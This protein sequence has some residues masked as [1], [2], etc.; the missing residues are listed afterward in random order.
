MAMG[1]AI[2]AITEA[3]APA[4]AVAALARGMELD[5]GN[6]DLY[7]A[8]VQTML[9]FDLPDLAVPAARALVALRPGDAV[10]WAV[11]G[12]DAARHG[13]LARAVTDVVLAA[14]LA[15]DDPFVLRTA[16]YV[17]AWYDTAPDR[18]AVPASIRASLDALRP[19]LADQ[20]AFNEAYGSAR[21]AY[22]ARAAG[23]AAPAGSQPAF[24][25]P[26]P[27][28][29]ALA[30][31][32]QPAL[33]GVPPSPAPLVT[34]NYYAAPY[35][36]GYAAEGS[37]YEYDGPYYPFYAGSYAPWCYG[38]GYA[39][40]ALVAFPQREHRHEHFGHGAGHEGSAAGRGADRWATPAPAASASAAGGTRVLAWGAQTPEPPE[41][42]EALEPPEA[43]RGVASAGIAGAPRGV[44]EGRTLPPM[45]WVTAPAA[46]RAQTVTTYNPGAAW[47]GSTW[48]GAESSGAVRWG[49]SMPSVHENGYY[50]SAPAAR[51]WAAPTYAAPQGGGFSRESGGGGYSGHAAGGGRGGG[52]HR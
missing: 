43:P 37:G 11:V 44:I 20:V 2:H 19:R 4:D 27:E 7:Q 1:D 10:A 13:G 28:A 29:V 16:G 46:P 14:H 25:P 21:A 3:D 24:P 9:R 32:T 50:Y 38:P 34:N 36:P 22:L 41:P 18:T 17:L 45:T 35:P 6:P 5:R 23:T 51:S 48:A 40:P 15:G 42:P 47:R 8:Y 26:A 12:L 30:P 33:P 52:G 39:G 49:G 31:G